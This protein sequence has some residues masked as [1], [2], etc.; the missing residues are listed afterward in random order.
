MVFT[1]AL[2]PFGAFHH[3]ESVPEC[4]GSHVKCA[5]KEHLKNHSENCLICAAHFEKN[6]TKVQ[7]AFRFYL[8]NKPV[9][10]SYSILAGNY[11]DLIGSSLRGPPPVL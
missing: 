6:Y 9:L 10:N 1:V 4:S 2:T 8:L 7:F 5:H 11:V 3:H